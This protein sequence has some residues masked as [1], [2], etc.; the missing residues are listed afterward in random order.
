MSGEVVATLDILTGQRAGETVQLTVQETMVLGNR[1]S[2]HIPIRDPWISWNHAKI[3][4]D[5]GSFWLEDLESSNGT[6]VN[7]QRVNRQELHHD[8]TLHLGR[9]KMRFSFPHGAS[10]RAPSGLAEPEPA[11][12]LSGWDG[13]GT[14]SMGA[15][16][17]LEELQNQVETLRA[18]KDRREEQLKE[19]LSKF[20]A[21]GQALQAATTELKRLQVKLQETPA[22]PDLNALKAQI[23]R[24]YE[25]R[26]AEANNRIQELAKMVK[27]SL[28]ESEKHKREGAEAALERDQLKVELES[29]AQS[30]GGDDEQRKKLEES[31]KK[32]KAIWEAEKKAHAENKAKLQDYLT[33]AEMT[34]QAAA[35]AEER[36]V[37][38]EAELLALQARESSNAGLEA[39]LTTLRAQV[40][41]LEG[42][43]AQAEAALQQARAEAAAAKQQAAAAQ[44]QAAAA[45]AQ[46]NRGAEV[47][48]LTARLAEKD[49][50]LAER[51]E[52][53]GALEEEIDALEA[54]VAELEAAGGGGGASAEELEELQA[55]VVRLEKEVEALGS[56][57]ERVASE[58]DRLK[59]EVTELQETV[60]ELEAELG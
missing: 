44:Q 27:D 40:G 30:G 42:A 41:Q 53:V 47:E 48:S 57:L 50:A 1:R 19:A 21:Q 25:D 22:P 17:E 32:L 58:R 45:A 23:G 13:V 55:E 52:Q 34:K 59:G 24:E 18:E 51:D 39:E 38:A 6:Y 9:T 46:A 60:E 28:D 26:L 35:A 49:A 36:A 5:S 10:F 43:K 4:F 3:T 11:V 15:R 20:K 33:K 8:D 54:R 31:F 16:S 7:G 2:A 56:E 29:Q 12:D 14:E 37:K